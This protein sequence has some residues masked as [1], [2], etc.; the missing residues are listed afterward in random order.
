M[1]E[2][3]KDSSQ[4]TLKTIAE[5][6]TEV[7]KLGAKVPEYWKKSS[8]RVLFKKG[9][10]KSPENYRPI[11]I[12]PILYKLFSKVLAGRIKEIL[13]SHQLLTRQ[14]PVQ[15]SAVTIIFSKLQYNAD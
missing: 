9:D 6:F 2:L 13:N 4:D 14:A 12:I 7:M 3:L 11:C 10:R 1:A 15:T 5:I 8:I